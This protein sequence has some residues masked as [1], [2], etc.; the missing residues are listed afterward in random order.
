M[1]NRIRELQNLASERGHSM[2]ALAQEVIGEFLLVR[3][4]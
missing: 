3:T 2:D 4:I 1:N